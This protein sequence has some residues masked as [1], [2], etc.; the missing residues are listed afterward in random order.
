MGEISTLRRRMIEDMTVHRRST[1]RAEGVDLF[2]PAVAR[3]PPGVRSARNCHIGSLGG[4]WRI[5]PT[6]VPARLPGS[7]TPSNRPHGCAGFE[8]FGLLRTIHRRARH[9]V[10]ICRELGHCD[11]INR[12]EHGETDQVAFWQCLGAIRRDDPRPVQHG[13]GSNWPG[14]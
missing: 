9:R 1:G 10:T 5:R 2:V 12:P 13:G 7:F 11:Q 6:K 8:F 14:R 3:Y 4:R